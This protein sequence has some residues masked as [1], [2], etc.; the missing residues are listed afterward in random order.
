MTGKQFFPHLI[1]QPFHHGLVIV[2][3]LAIIMSLFSAGVSLLR[4]KHYVHDDQATPVP[5]GGSLEAAGGLLVES[6]ESTQA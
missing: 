2:F 3:T 1:A 4:G 6:A 5:S